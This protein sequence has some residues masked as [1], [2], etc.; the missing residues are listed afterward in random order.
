MACSL[1]FFNDFWLYSDLWKVSITRRF[2]H[3]ANN[4]LY[5]ISPHN[6]NAA[7]AQR[8]LSPGRARGSGMSAPEPVKRGKE[9][10]VE[11]VSVEKKSFF[12]SA[13][14]LLAKSDNAAGTSAQQAA[15][16]AKSSAAVDK[17]REPAL[18]NAASSVDTEQATT[19]FVVATAAGYF[20]SFSSFL[21]STTQAEYI[22]DIHASF[23]PYVH[24]AI[25]TSMH[26][27]IHTQTDMH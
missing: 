27:C 6:Y 3:P 20:V 5:K 18:K 13:A 25:L 10:A 24:A 21:S 8:S 16:P 22:R 26:A 17:S 12:A 23:H 1:P 11:M 14:A 19:K 7:V 2:L 15:N 9:D 4:N